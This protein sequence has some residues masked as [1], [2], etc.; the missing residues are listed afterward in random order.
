[1]RKLTL[2]LLVSILFVTMNVA[3]AGIYFEPYFG[4]F[5]NGEISGETYD[6]RH[7]LD[8]DNDTEESV[9]GNGYGARVGMDFINVAFGIDY[10]GAGSKSGDTTSTLT[11]MG[12]FLAFKIP[13]FRFW[14]EYIFSA[15]I[16]AEDEDG[17]KIEY[18]KGSG[19]KIGVG[20]TPIPFLSINFEVMNNTFTSL[21]FEDENGDDV[22]EAN[23]Y[24]WE[25][26]EN[27]FTTYFL[28]LSVPI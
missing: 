14:A 28:S 22:L 15:S 5:V 11:N 9:T 27:K 7:D 8:S 10:M 3:K 1:M 20:Y 25:D 2:L 6:E 12:A 17:N 13:M 19:T 26:H 18:G 24:D 21:S 23:N 4:T 16:K